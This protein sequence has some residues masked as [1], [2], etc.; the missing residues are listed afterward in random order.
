MGTCACVPPIWGWRPDFFLPISEY[1]SERNP[2]LR[3]SVF[4]ISEARLSVFHIS[5]D[6]TERSEGAHRG[7]REE[8]LGRG[9]SSMRSFAALAPLLIGRIK[10]AVVAGLV[11][12]AAGWAALSLTVTAPSARGLIIF[13]RGHAQPV[14][15]EDQNS[16]RVMCRSAERAPVLVRVFFVPRSDN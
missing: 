12:D 10:F 11:S 14:A 7:A 9:H 15:D 5:E 16:V 4:H 1:A 2:H 8:A 13:P 6:A 3:V